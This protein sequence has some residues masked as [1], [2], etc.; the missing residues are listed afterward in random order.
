VT[1]LGRA[2]RQAKL[3]LQGV[4]PGGRTALL[5]SDALHTAGEDPMRALGGLD[6]LHVLGT[7]E[8]A[9]AVAAGRA[10]ARRGHG[11]YLPAARLA[12]LTQS[13]R[14]ALA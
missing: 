9:D 4:P 8:E 14:D 1:D 6:C 2:L 5:M 13:L 3:L 12:Q 7:S 11:R 10:L